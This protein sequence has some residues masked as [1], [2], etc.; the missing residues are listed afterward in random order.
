M[1]I[2]KE[3]ILNTGADMNLK[4]SLGSHD[5]FTGYQQEIDKL[6]QFTSI[7]LVNPVT[8]GEVKKFGMSPSTPV[9]NLNFSFYN[10]SIYGATYHYAGF[11]TLADQSNVAKQN[12]FYVLDFY[13]TFDPYT[14]R[15]IFSTY[16]TKLGTSSVST[17]T[18]SSKENQ[19]FYWYVP[20]YYI[21]EQTGTTCI[22]YIKFTFI[23][24]KLG[25]T[26]LFNNQNNAGLKTAEKMY[27]KVELDLLNMTWKVLDI[28]SSTLYAREIVLNTE[29]IQKI[30][31]TYN[32]TE[33]IQQVYPTGNTFN[34]VDG[35]Y[36]IT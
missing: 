21:D 28:V 26:T 22:G 16:L 30:N 18:I 29:Y 27:F 31:D 7:D 35:D 1:S 14:Q 24:A 9:T 20:K 34:Y 13:D 17:Y 25:D 2:I 3:R 8:D 15:K 33:N 6:T 10:G 36:F 12:S 5:S 23:N 11:T 4:I 32:K 19:L